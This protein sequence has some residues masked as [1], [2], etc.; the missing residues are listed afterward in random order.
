MR[1]LF[2]ARDPRQPICDHMVHHL[3]VRAKAAASHKPGGIH[4]LDHVFATLDVDG[5]R[6]ISA[7]R[8]FLF[9][10][11]ALSRAFCHRFLARL[12]AAWQQRRLIVPASLAAA[13]RSAVSAGPITPGVARACLR[14]HDRPVPPAARLHIAMHAGRS[15]VP[16]PRR[17]PDAA[18]DRCFQSP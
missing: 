17:G 12:E 14:S 18:W 6:W 7:R 1:R 13:A 9:P 4:L 8:T 16:W 15:T 11:R 10:V 5:D 3:F 2:S